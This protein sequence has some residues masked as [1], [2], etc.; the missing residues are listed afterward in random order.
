MPLPCE[1]PQK[2]TLHYL[3]GMGKGERQQ[4]QALNF[5]DFVKL[6]SSQSRVG[7]VPGAKELHLIC[8][9]W[10][11]L[12][13]LSFLIMETQPGDYRFQQA[14]LQNEPSSPGAALET[15]HCTLGHSPEGWV[16]KCSTKGYGDSRVSK[17]RPVSFWS[18]RIGLLTLFS[19]LFL[20][21]IPHFSEIL[22]LK[23]FD[24]LTFEGFYAIFILE[25]SLGF[26][27]ASQVNLFLLGQEASVFSPEQHC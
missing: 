13:L 22:F 12:P 18:L 26:I 7:N 10:S 24:Q 2:R 11:R 14:T 23:M 17:K 8:L 3:Q 15:E 6:R 25:L 9:K 5:M 19:L 16:L 27:N 20:Y 1:V 21:Y 4:S